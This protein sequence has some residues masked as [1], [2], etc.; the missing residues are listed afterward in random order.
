MEL[1]LSGIYIHIYIKYLRFVG[2][3][4]AVHEPEYADA[5]LTFTHN[6]E[7]TPRAVSLTRDLCLCRRVGQHVFRMTIIHPRRSNRLV[8]ALLHV[9]V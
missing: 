7:V 8:T 5:I 4:Y 3:G 2:K 9:G 6:N 1:W